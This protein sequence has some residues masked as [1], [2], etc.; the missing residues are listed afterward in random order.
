MVGGADAILLAAGRIGGE[1]AQ[2]AGTQRKAFINCRAWPFWNGQSSP[3]VPCLPSTA[4]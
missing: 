2:V 3:F 1:Y 4:S